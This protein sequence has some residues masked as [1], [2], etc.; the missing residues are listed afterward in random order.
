MPGTVVRGSPQRCAR[1]RPGVHSR[2]ARTARGS[3][4]SQTQPS[5]SQ[6]PPALQGGGWFLTEAQSLFSQTAS[7]SVL[8]W[9]FFSSLSPASSSSEQRV[10][11]ELSPAAAGESPLSH[12]ALF[13]LLLAL[14]G[15]LCLG[16]GEVDFFLSPLWWQAG[17]RGR[18]TRPREERIQK[19]G[20]L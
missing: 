17:M 5:A 3:R 8:V 9:D 19:L 1:L 4:C 18:T 14:A 2:C 10:P 6:L 20:E 13:V 16:P 11:E 12:P 7:H 15:G